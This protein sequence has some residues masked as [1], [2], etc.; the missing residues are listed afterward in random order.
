M[1]FV[2]QRTCND[3]E[4]GFIVFNESKSN[5]CNVGEHHQSEPT[6]R[7]T[8]DIIMYWIFVNV[9]PQTIKVVKLKINC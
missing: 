3:S 9:Y 8:I 2:C 4:K 5:G 1:H 7:T 6:Y